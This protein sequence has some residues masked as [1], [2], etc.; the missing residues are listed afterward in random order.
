[1]DMNLGG[2]YSTQCTLSLSVVRT[3]IT[4]ARAQHSTAGG[5]AVRAATAAGAIAVTP[6]TLPPL[7]SPLPVPPSAPQ[8]W[9]LIC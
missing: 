5:S 4:E 1:M 7:W 3:K 9:A 8:M 2:Y 6:F